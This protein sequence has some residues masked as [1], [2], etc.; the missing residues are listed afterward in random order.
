VPSLAMIGY[1]GAFLLAALAIAI[2]H[3]QNRDL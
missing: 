3:F 2:Y 1:A